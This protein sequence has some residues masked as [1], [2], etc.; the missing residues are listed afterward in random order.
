MYKG[1]SVAI[2]ENANH[3]RKE[4]TE[5]EDIL[6]QHLR[7]RKL[8]GIKFRRQHPMNQFI[9][10]FYANEKNLAIELD[11]GIHEKAEVKEYDKNR[12]FELNR[13][14]IKVVRFKNEEVVNDV[15]RVMNEIRKFL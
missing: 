3:L 1:T 11:G 9:L 14:G 13:M 12:T 6:W 5:A 7:N 10:D 15:Q 8:E 4:L 2:F